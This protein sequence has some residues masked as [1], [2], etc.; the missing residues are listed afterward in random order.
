[1]QHKEVKVIEEQVRRLKLRDKVMTDMVCLSG[2]ADAWADWT[3]SD[4]LR[5]WRGT[6]VPIICACID[7]RA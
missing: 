1:V 2:L 4:E 5:P 7:H 3:H 6:N